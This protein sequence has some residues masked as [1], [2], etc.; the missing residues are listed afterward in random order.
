M[1]DKGDAAKHAPRDSGYYGGKH[2]K[3]GCLN[4]LIGVFVFIAITTA[5]I[6]YQI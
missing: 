2:E 1:R 5:A 6:L 4:I 3:P